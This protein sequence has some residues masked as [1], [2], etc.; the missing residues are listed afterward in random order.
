MDREYHDW[1][2]ARIVL[3]TSQRSEEACLEE[4]VSACDATLTTV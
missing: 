2:A 3:D 4:L 1:T